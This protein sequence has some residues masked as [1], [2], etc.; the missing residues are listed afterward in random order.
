MTESKQSSLIG[1]AL[2]N[3]TYKYTYTVHYLLRTVHLILYS[4]YVYVYMCKLC[5]VCCTYALHTLTV[6]YSALLEKS[7]RI[8]MFAKLYT[9]GDV[10]FS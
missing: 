4:M 3:D 7:W 10:K 8:L 1:T 9:V 5:S 2:S 6:Y